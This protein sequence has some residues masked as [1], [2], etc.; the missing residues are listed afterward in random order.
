MIIDMS[1]SVADTAFGKSD[2]SKP[3]NK[4]EF[5]TEVPK[6]PIRSLVSVFS[7][8]LFFAWMTPVARATEQDQARA[9][10][11]MTDEL[12][13]LEAEVARLNPIPGGFKGEV[14]IFGA[15]AS[16]H[17]YFPDGPDRP[18]VAAL[19]LPSIAL[20]TIIP[21][22]KGTPMDVTL[23]NPIVFATRAGF[24]HADKMPSDVA[25]RAQAI[26][27]ASAF[28]VETALNVFGTVAGHDDVLHQV[29]RLIN[30]KS[31]LVAGYS[32]PSGKKVK[33]KPGPDDDDADAPKDKK[34]S[35]RV[36]SLA[37]PA[38]AT[39]N[40]PFFMKDVTIE[41]IAIQMRTSKDPLLDP[42]TRL[43]VV[44]G[45]GIGQPK[46][47]YDLYVEKTFDKTLDPANLP[48]LVAI[49]PRGEVTLAD[50]LSISQAVGATLDLP[51]RILSAGSNL[52]LDLVKLKNPFPANE[53]FPEQGAPPDFSKVMFAGANGKAKIPG[54]LLP[55]PLLTANADATIFGF[56]AAGLRANF[57]L[58]GLNA[59]AMAQ[60]PKL[61]P[62]AVTD[63][64]L[65]VASKRMQPI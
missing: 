43:L 30:L 53:A 22:L 10:F 2:F 31:P 54:R 32:S 49:N 27:L 34:L 40:E 46:K 48:M 15:T 62:I 12:K 1:A 6:M 51:T 39:W 18:P 20:S 29:L 38:N 8:F 37:L 11:S 19:L 36:L 61:G 42:S 55:G 60:I 57:A 63:A 64:A 65:D 24:L 23:D 56:N 59:K 58:S 9:L 3:P 17:V 5:E 14:S 25:A 44:G 7:F 41:Q 50:F 35:D 52:P 16:V 21:P 47:T 33:L 45:A 13:S 26:G 28:R 4:N